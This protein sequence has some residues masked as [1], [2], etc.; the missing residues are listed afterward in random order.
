MD[1][2]KIY[3]YTLQLT[4]NSNIRPD[5][6]TIKS[7]REAIE[8]LNT[9]RHKYPC[10]P[11]IPCQFLGHEEPIPESLYCGWQRWRFKFESFLRRI[12][13]ENLWSHL[14]YKIFVPSKQVYLV[15][16]L[17]LVGHPMM[18]DAIRKAR[19]E[20]DFYIGRHLTTRSPLSFWAVT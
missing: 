13:A 3:A 11:L 20:D 8:R 16:G 1:N 10:T 5:T 4:A 14:S 7:V 9:E 19:D 12:G 17:G 2:T 6:V 15:D 18:I